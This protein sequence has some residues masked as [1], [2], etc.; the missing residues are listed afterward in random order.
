MSLTIPPQ[1]GLGID[2]G[3]TATRWAVATATGEVLAEGR[4]AG[5]T[6]LMMKDDAG[7]ETLRSTFAQLAQDACAAIG[8]TSVGRVCA[9]MTGYDASSQTR[10]AAGD[11]LI[12][13]IAAALAVNTS[14]VMLGNDVEIAYHDFFAPGEGYVV[15]AGTGSIAAFIDTENVMHRAGGRG[16]LLDD[17]GSGYWIA[18]EALRHIWRNEDEAPGRWRDSPMAVETFALIGG[19]DWV[20]S[21]NFM[22]GNKSRGDIGMLAL[23]VAKSADR[24]PAALA[25]LQA[26]GVELARLGNAMTKRYGARPIALLGG[27]ATLHPIIAEVCHA[28][29][30][31]GTTL[32]IAVSH[33]HIAAARIAA[34][35]AT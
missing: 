2:A 22:Y 29:L 12:D 7:R 17:G 34:K 10:N 21:R 16:G 9:G 18:R 23:A 4:V 33:A 24:D 6:G 1:I 26:A 32:T 13:L 25:I 3:G 5:L 11:A 31:A 8:R 20:D 15:Y 14:A 30:P 27:A 35:M 19:S 28:H